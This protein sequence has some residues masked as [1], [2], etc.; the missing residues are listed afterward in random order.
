M[1][2]ETYQQLP[3]ENKVSSR[4]DIR[5]SRYDIQVSQREEY[6]SR[7]EERQR[8]YEI[9]RHGFEPL[10]AILLIVLLS[11]LTRSLHWI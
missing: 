5:T 9:Y 10:A 3:E 11:I 8:P 6:L 1:E 7:E 4:P 2:I